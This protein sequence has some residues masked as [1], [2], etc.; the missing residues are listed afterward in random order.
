LV[1]A[2]EGRKNFFG[3][4]KSDHKFENWGKMGPLSPTTV[5]FSDFL[6]FGSANSDHKRPSKSDHKIFSNSDHKFFWVLKLGSLSTI[7]KNFSRAQAR[8][9]NFL[10]SYRRSCLSSSVNLGPLIF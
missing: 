6:D 10:C 4:S 2:A 3:S 5:I 9:K 7:T 1:F 8:E